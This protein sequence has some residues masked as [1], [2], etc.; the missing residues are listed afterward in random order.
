MNPES[1]SPEEESVL[2]ELAGELSR[3]EQ[4]K[5]R[6]LEA[7]DAALAS[8]QTDAESDHALA[9]AVLGAARE[10]EILPQMPASVLERLELHRRSVSQDGSATN[11]ASF[12][13]AI[14]SRRSSWF[15]AMAAILVVL[16]VVIG[17]ELSRRISDQPTRVATI[18]P[19]LAPRG[20]TSV[21]EPLIVWENAPNQD[22]DVWILPADGAVTE[23]ASLFVKK[24]VRSPIPF[25]QLEPADPGDALEAGNDYRVLVCLADQG[26]LAGESVSFSIMEQ[27]TT[28]VPQPTTADAA[29]SIVRRLSAGGRFGDA[30]MVVEQLPPAERSDPRIV[31]E[32]E[33]LKNAMSN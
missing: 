13:S 26:R 22:Y 15:W 11:L 7:G 6:G 21:T 4:D 29:L 23:V 16:L 27:A 17:P 28:R 24:A 8:F 25:D 18:A 20:V 30:I 31:L 5:L 12:P 10:Q 32:W 2:L 14:S 9:D 33:N 3:E 1:L 19:A